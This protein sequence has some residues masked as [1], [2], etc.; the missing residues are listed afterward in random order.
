[1]A[2]VLLPYANAYVRSVESTAV[3][4]VNGR[5]QPSGEDICIFKCFLKRAQYSGTSSGSK[6][7]P[8]PSQLGGEM[9][10]GV[11]GDAYYYRGYALQCAIVAP[12]FDWLVDDLD[13][14]TWTDLTASATAL[15]PG[16]RVQ[17]LFGDTPE[18][19]AIVERSSGVFGGTGIDSI[20][21][22][23]LGGVELQ[24]SGAEVVGL[25]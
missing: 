12:I 21:Y 7:Q 8:L 15:R 10:P 24:L 25:V 17:F 13:A 16:A 2:S 5:I 22:S 19:T 14:L 3:S 20:L 4:V 11:G 6:K 18:M 23:E 9:M 1:M